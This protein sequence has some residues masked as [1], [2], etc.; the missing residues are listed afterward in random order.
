MGTYPNGARQ[1]GASPPRA[2]GSILL[3][4]ATPF[5]PENTIFAS[6]QAS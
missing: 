3:E 2:Q 4:D 1:L 6:I 5:V